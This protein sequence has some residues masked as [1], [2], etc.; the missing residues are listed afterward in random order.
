MVI[1]LLGV[2][3]YVAYAMF[4]MSKIDPEEK[5]TG[6]ILDIDG[7]SCTDFVDKTE[8]EEMLKA[9]HMY[10]KG[11]L[12]KD[13]N[14]R[15]IETELKTN[16]F[17]ESVECYKSSTGKLCIRIVQRTPV[18]YALPDNAAGYFVDRSGKIL[19]NTN[20]AANII[21][22]TGHFTPDYAASKLAPLGVYLQENPFWNNQ[23]EQVYVSVSRGNKYV[24][25]LVPRV[26]D[27]TIYLGDIDGFE[28][29]L[30]RLKIFYEKAMRCV[31]WNK[32][33]KINL[34]YNNQIICTKQKN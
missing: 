12:M 29:K 23:I 28:K 21:T 15:G 32:Y 17:I 25:E 18:V 6:L 1:L 5:C 33:D 11:M 27:Q 7:R 13:V 10:P 16:E 19:S 24:V 20:Y 31:G 30:R 9:A 2:A 14:T 3:A 8:V 22:A 34:E 26:G 4:D